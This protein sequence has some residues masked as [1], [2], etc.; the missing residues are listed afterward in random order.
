MLDFVQAADGLRE[1]ATAATSDAAQFEEQRMKKDEITKLVDSGLDE[2]NDALKKGQSDDLTRLF[3]VMARFTHYSFNNRLLIAKQNP[4][5]TRVLGFHGWRK[6]GRT[7]RKGEKGIGITAPI[8]YRKEKT[9]D[10]SMEIRG[11]RVVHVFDIEQTEGDELLSFK[12]PTGDCNA[13]MERTEQLIVSKDI[14][15]RYEELKRGC[16]GYSAKGKTV[17]QSDLSD[18]KRLATLLHE[19]AHELLHQRQVDLSESPSRAIWETEAEAVAHVVGRALGLETCE[20]SADYIHLHQ[21][22]SEVLAKSMQRIQ[23]CAGQILSDLMNAEP[24]PTESAATPT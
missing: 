12:Q 7:V 11:F 16:Y 2:L 20:H 6:L 13:W 4:D 1:L 17:I 8:A 21:G 5:A 9:D 19:L 18:A 14:E 15:L 24:L 22:D 23:K 3:A 10:Q